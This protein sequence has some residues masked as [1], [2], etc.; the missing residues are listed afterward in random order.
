MLLYNQKVV[1]EDQMIS[2]VDK[3]NNI[4]HQSSKY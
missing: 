1:D 2:Y 3:V 4:K